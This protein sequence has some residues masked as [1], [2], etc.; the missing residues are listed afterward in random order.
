MKK[1][2]KKCNSEF[3]ANHGRTIYCSTECKTPN[4]RHYNLLKRYGLS[5]SDWEEMFENQ[6]RKCA[7]CKKDDSGNSIYG[8][9]VDHCHSTGK[10]RAILCM[11]CNTGLGAF[12]DNIDIILN[13][14]S[15]ILYHSS[16]DNIESGRR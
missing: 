7:I 11:K 12:R 10:V 8:W 3:E 1:N 6:E 14:A 4:R 15:Y 13:A 2:C 16:F 9:A 5:E